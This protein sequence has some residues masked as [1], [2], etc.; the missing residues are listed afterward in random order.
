MDFYNVKVS[1]YKSNKGDKNM[2]KL[3]SI[4]LKNI[5]SLAICMLFLS[6]NTT[7]NWLSHQPTVPRDINRFKKHSDN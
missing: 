6:A 2:K 1:K 5:G 3:Y 4:V 7:C